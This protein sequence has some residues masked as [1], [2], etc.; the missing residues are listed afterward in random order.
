M[1]REATDFKRIDVTFLICMWT[2]IPVGSWHLSQSLKSKYNTNKTLVVAGD[3]C[4]L[5][6]RDTY[7]LCLRYL[8]S[9]YHDVVVVMGNHE[10]YNGT[11]Y[12]V[13]VRR[14]HKACLDSEVVGLHKSSAEVDGVQFAGCTLWS[15]PKPSLEG[16]NYCFKDSR[17]CPD[18]TADKVRRLHASEVTWLE[19]QDLTHAVVMTHHLP[20]K[21]LVSSDSDLLQSRGLGSYFWSN[22]ERLMSKCKLWICGHRHRHVD[23]TVNGCRCV[24]HPLGYANGVESPLEVTVPR[25]LW[26]SLN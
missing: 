8:K 22:Q 15:H 4:P 26:N 16:T 21:E 1:I 19:S 13:T 10:Y 14:F 3:V 24:C 23:I 11:S 6:Y 7:V 20:S 2:K 17:Y 5:V 9:L 18:L 12:D 25:E